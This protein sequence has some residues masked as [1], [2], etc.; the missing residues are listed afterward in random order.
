MV[1][2][3]REGW[4]CVSARYALAL[5]IRDTALGAILLALGTAIL[6]RA[7]GW[8][9][10]LLLV[11]LPAAA[12][13]STVMSILN[14]IAVVRRR[15]EFPRPIP[16]PYLS[17]S[18]FIGFTLPWIIGVVQRERESDRA[19]SISENK[20]ATAP[21][22]SSIKESVLAGDFALEWPSPSLVA[23]ESRVRETDA[24]KIGNKYGMLAPGKPHGSWVAMRLL[25]LYY[26]SIGLVVSAVPTLVFLLL[27]Q[28]LFQG[29]GWAPLRE[30]EATTS[31]VVGIFFGIVCGAF[32][33]FGVGYVL[34]GS[35]ALLSPK[36]VLGSD[37]RLWIFADPTLGWRVV[38]DS[39]RRSGMVQKDSHMFSGSVRDS[40]TPE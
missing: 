10:F 33:A 27:A 12:A 36:L 31:W 23:L 35:I 4:R 20:T 13:L 5:T 11:A 28:E 9:Q 25:G 6:L 30:D 2:K 39:V 18:L 16:K 8:G 14:L 37:L 17:V 22:S 7:K 1:L 34:A 40:T 3:M 15:N 38:V 32:A 26:V 24:T 21:A 29:S 19:R